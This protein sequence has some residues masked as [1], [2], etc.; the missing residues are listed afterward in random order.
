VHRGRG[1]GPLSDYRSA[2]HCC[3]LLSVVAVAVAAAACC[4]CR[5]VTRGVWRVWQR[6]QTHTGRIWA[7]LWVQRHTRGVG[8]EVAA[9]QDR[10]LVR[11]QELDKCGPVVAAEQLQGKLG[12]GVEKLACSVM[13]PLWY[14]WLCTGS[15]QSACGVVVCGVVC[16]VMGKRW[17]VCV[18]E[19]VGGVPVWRTALVCVGEGPTHVAA[20]KQGHRHN[21]A[22]VGGSEETAAGGS[23]GSLLAACGG[24]D[25][26]AGASITAAAAAAAAAAGRLGGV[27]GRGIAPAASLSVGSPVQANTPAGWGASAAAEVWRCGV[28]VVSE[29]WSKHE[30]VPC[31]TGVI[32]NTLSRRPGSV[33]GVVLC[34]HRL[35]HALGLLSS[36]PL[37]AC[38]Q[39]LPC[40]QGLVEGR[41]G[42]GGR[43]SGAR[44]A[45]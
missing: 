11:S 16:G 25:P 41:K 42:G 23:N 9:H 3:L 5:G 28:G 38:M 14:Y 30:A 39:H 31:L 10:L 4:V 18:E 17:S 33:G 44:V 20:V 22:A 40:C 2:D 6:H 21:S 24:W 26:A 45:V 27:G 32:A 7:A 36:S 29:T 1:A 15:F 37:R 43:K 8:G 34:A 13:S 12:V 19:E 35:A